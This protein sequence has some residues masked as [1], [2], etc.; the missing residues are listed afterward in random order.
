M[1]DPTLSL[2]YDKL[3]IRVAE[4]LGIA[5]YGAAGDQA[6]QLPVDAGDLD[7]VSRLVNDGYDRFIGENE[8]WNFLSVPLTL[9]FLTGTVSAD[10]ARYYLPDDFYG[11]LLSRFTYPA[12]GPRITIENIDEQ[13]IRELQA[14]ASVTGYPSVVAVRAINTTASTTAQRWEAIFWPTPQTALTVTG[15]YKR[16]P[17]ALSASGDTSIAGFQH[18]RTVLA[19]CIA[20]AELQKN[21]EQGPR[22]AFYQQMLQRSLR[23]DKRA[24]PVSLGDYGDKSEEHGTGQRPLNYYGVNTY[25]GVSIE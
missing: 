8:K 24:S 11:I 9:T 1:A 5:Y 18:D 10:N 17:A 2:S 7:T 22:E 12:A 16:Y 13:R 3:R 14:G 19:A 25:N 21:D 20:A 23:L 6:A 4:Y 15:M